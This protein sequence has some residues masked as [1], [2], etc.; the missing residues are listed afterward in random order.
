MGQA[1][2]SVCAVAGRVKVGAVVPRARAR[3]VFGEPR[4]AVADAGVDYAWFEAYLGDAWYTFDPRNNT[5]RIGTDSDRPR[6]D[7]ADVP[8][9]ISFG[10]S[11]LER[12][13][14]WTN[15]IRAN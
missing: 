9:T 13:K 12:F 1:L 11:T 5:P 6:R 15:E 4:I 2:G 7:A 10:P 14:V 3:N 8:L